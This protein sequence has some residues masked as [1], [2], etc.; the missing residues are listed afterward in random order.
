M[1]Y[2]TVGAVACDTAGR[3]SAATSTGGVTNLKVKAVG[4]VKVRRV[5]LE[6]IR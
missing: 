3:L 4:A 1:K 5:S 2:G 6:Q